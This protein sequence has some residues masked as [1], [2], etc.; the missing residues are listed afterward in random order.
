[1][2]ARA[3][4]LVLASAVLAAGCGG[5]PASDRRPKIEAVRAYLDRSGGREAVAQPVIHSLDLARNLNCARFRFDR[6][7][8]ARGPDLGG[9]IPTTRQRLAYG[10]VRCRTLVG[11]ESGPLRR[12]LGRPDQALGS[13][14]RW[15]TGPERSAFAIASELLAVRF[16]AGRVRVAELIVG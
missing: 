11:R 15:V 4:A 12:L 6:R 8:W 16:R 13:E 10:L 3:A 1:M 14:W 5:G 2:A 7:A 9:K